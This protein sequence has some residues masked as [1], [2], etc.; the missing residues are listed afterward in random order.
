MD[1]GADPFALGSVLQYKPLTAAS[2][3]SSQY[4]QQMQAIQQMQIDAMKYGICHSKIR[5]ICH[6]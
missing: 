1:L 3:S 5:V 6:D 4:Y 2:V